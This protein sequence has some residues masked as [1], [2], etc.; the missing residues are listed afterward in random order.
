MLPTQLPHPR[1]IT[2][3]ETS[4]MIRPKR[5]PERM[6]DS[7]RL[8]LTLSNAPERCVIRKYTTP[9]T[10]AKTHRIWD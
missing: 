3:A 7:A 8:I 9:K 2:A 6:T 4:A 1:T 10:A 5:A